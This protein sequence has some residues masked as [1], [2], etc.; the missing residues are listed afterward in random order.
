M[1]SNNFKKSSLTNYFE[2]IDHSQKQ[3]FEV[4]DCGQNKQYQVSKVVK[5]LMTN[6]TTF[7]LIHIYIYFMHININS[8]KAQEFSLLFNKKYC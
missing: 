3:H 4:F 2:D 1:E 5:P 7:I 8:K 6:L